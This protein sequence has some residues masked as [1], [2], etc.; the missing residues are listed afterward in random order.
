MKAIFKRYG[1]AFF[2]LVTAIHL[3]AIL[4]L[5]E[6][7]RFITKPLLMPLLAL[8][9][10]ADSPGSKQRNIILIAILFSFLGDTFLL[11]DYKNPLYF[12]F[13]LVS[14]L[15]THILYIIYFLGV[16]PGNSISTST[17]NDFAAAHGMSKET[18]Y[19]H[20]EN[21]ITKAMVDLTGKDN[22]Y[23]R[24][25]PLKKYPWIFLLVIVY[26]AGLVYFLFPK[27][28][29]LKIPVMVYATVIC[30]ML[31]AAIHVL[32]SFRDKDICIHTND[33]F[34]VIKNVSGELFVNGALLFVVS[35]SLLAINK[36]YAVFPSSAFLIML[37]YCAAQYSIAKGFVKTNG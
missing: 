14:F 8:A 26:G 23:A 36:F 15:I 12:I 28:G 10:Y 17:M 34:Y 35:D 29:E 18:F 37:S 2:L 20:Q 30:C 4:L 21:E 25:S 6:D 7:G 24:S 11:F 9:V 16:K 33:T 22:E 5:W 32:N 27:L 19:Q 13:G 1:F 31:L 3:L